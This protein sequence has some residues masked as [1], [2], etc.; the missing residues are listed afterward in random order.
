MSFFAWLVALF[1]QKPQ[2]P[3]PPQPPAPKLRPIG[4]FTVPNATVKLDTVGSGTTNADGYYCWPEVDAALSACHVWVTAK[5]FVPYDQHIDLTPQQVG[6][7]IFVGKQR[8]DGPHPYDIYLPAL[9]ADHVDPS[10]FSLRELARIRGAMWTVRGPWA[11]GPRPAQPSNITALEYLHVYGD[12][13]T[14]PD[15]KHLTQTQKDILATYKSFGYTH[16]CYG[17]IYGQAYHGLYPDVQFNTPAMFE[18]WLD[19]LQVFWDNG[20]APVCFIHPDN[21]TFDE[22]KAMYDPLI[23]GNARAQKL[24]RI[25]V[26]TGWEPTRYDWSSYTW[27]KYFEWMKELLP[28]ALLLL[29]TVPDVDAPCGKDELGDDE[30]DQAAGNPT[31]DVRVNAWRRLCPLIHGWLNQSGAFEHPDDHND[32]NNPQFTAFDNWANGFDKTYKGS[33]YDR[34][35]NGYAGWP[36][37]SAWGNEPIKIYAGEFCSYWEYWQDRAYSEGVAWGDRALKVGAD[38]VLDSCSPTAIIP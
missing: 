3:T 33:Y 2:P 20:L 27:A 1:R 36:G 5:D 34:F 37:N 18:Q 7:D 17:P 25:V 35:H 13:P 11:Y 10:K 12:N 19:W 14:S 23:R 22:T 31:H 8:P 29:Q 16:C 24:M 21:L 28:N 15:P 38:G 30:A 32:P 9:T 26:P 4:I 6:Q